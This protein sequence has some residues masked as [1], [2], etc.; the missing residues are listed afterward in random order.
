MKKHSQQTAVTVDTILQPHHPTVID[1]VNQ[2]R[3]QI[4][5]TVPEAT[6]KAYPVWK[7]IGYVHP[8]AGYFCAI[9]P[10]ADCVKLGFEWGKLLPDTDGVLEGDGK[11][12][13]YVVIREGESI[14]VEAI[15]RLLLA[16]LK[17][18]AERQV[19]LAL[20]AGT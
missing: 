16:A 3:H 15:K 1:L 8:I 5:A 2:L 11:Q 9:F 14:P 19:K 6:E 7:G 18:P 12:L 4:R 20:L 17:L 10:Q 13:R